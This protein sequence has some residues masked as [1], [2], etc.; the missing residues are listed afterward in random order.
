M[1]RLVMILI[2]VA[3][4]G[5]SISL[6]PAARG[7]TDDADLSLS[8]ADVVLFNTNHD[9]SFCHGVHGT[10]T[11]L[12]KVTTTVEAL[13]MSCH[14]PTGTSSLKAEVHT[15][16]PTGNSCCGAFRVTCLDC[17]E[18][19]SNQENHLSQPGAE[20]YN[21]KLVRDSVVSPSSGTRRA[22]VFESRGPE[23][24]QPSLYSFCDDDEDNNS[25]WDQVC[26]VCHEDPDLRRHHFD[27]TAN[28][29]QNGATCTKSGC[30]VH[31]NALSP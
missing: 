14:G 4:A 24:S 10:S 23:F 21:L 12:L 7:R 26:D 3:A 27:G 29:H 19:H 28:H 13:C 11:Q 30:H 1:K 8:G 2:L 17:H 5:A 20:R 15:N 18:P 31:S 22:I 6:T 9:C 16:D 25:V